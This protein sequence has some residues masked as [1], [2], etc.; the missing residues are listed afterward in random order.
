MRPFV[1]LPAWSTYRVA[2]AGWAVLSVLA[3]G[4]A[5]LSHLPRHQGAY[6]V[7]ADGGRHWLQGENLYESKD[8]RSLLV[9]RYSPLVAV[10][11]VPVGA[12]PDKLGNGL[13]RL[14]GLAALLGS[15]VW[16][17]RASLPPRFSREQRGGFFLLCAA[18]VCVTMMD[19]QLTILTLSC[20]LCAAA[21][22]AQKRWN[23]AALACALAVCLKAYPL[24]FALVLSVLFPRRF[25]GRFV[26]LLLVCLA[27][28]FALQSHGYVLRQYGEWI[29]FGLNQ[30]RG[31]H[32]ADFMQVCRC[33]GQPITLSTY[34][35]VQV[36]SGAGIALV[37]TVQRWRQVSHGR[38]VS[39]AF[40][41][42]CGWML[43]FGPAT[44]PPTYILLAPALA[45]ATLLAWAT[46]QR[47]WYRL[48]I[49]LSFAVL[50]AAQLQLLFPFK[51][52]VH[53]V[54]GHPLAALLFLVA[55]AVNALTSPAKEEP[56]CDR[57]QS[58]LNRVRPFTSITATATRVR[59]EAVD[60]CR[61]EVVA[62]TVGG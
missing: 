62:M 47:S 35:M 55:V 20:L 21:A 60:A 27:L 59:P 3:L 53:G 48:A 50:A 5:A 7:F 1:R 37:C 30:R 49:S 40:Q 15:L 22:A 31:E 16:W 17:A 46:P 42:C 19:V 13:L 14:E 38:L 34:Q 26:L 45:G 23:V 43:V 28:P 32:F 18:L 36:A 39:L 33:W 12:L 58:P 8:L 11:L 29:C 25:A 10:Y 6:H 9:F 61:G 56:E 44:E 52:M 54:A 57:A 4:R 51:R 41:L 2:W 24:A